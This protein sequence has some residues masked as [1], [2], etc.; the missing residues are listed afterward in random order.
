MLKRN[1]APEKTDLANAFTQPRKRSLF[2]FKALKLSDPSI[3]AALVLL[4]VGVAFLL[5][6][7]P[8]MAQD[9]RRGWWIRC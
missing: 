4:G 7:N 9:S 6:A 3:L 5:N 8:A 2:Q 1:L